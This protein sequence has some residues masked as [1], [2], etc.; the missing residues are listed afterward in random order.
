[1][2]NIGRDVTPAQASLSCHHDVFGM[3]C[4]EVAE[5]IGREPACV[6]QAHQPRPPASPGGAPALFRRPEDGLRIAAAFFTAS[7]TGDMAALRALLAEEVVATAD[8]GGKVPASPM[9]LIGR[10]A[11]LVRH[12]AMARDFGHDPSRLVRYATIDGLP[13]FVTVEAGAIVQ[14]TAL[15]VRDDAVAAIYVVRNPDESIRVSRLG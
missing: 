6:P 14:T 7:R 10:E 11:V 12:S 5:A 9:P 4:P 15:W 2:G 8:G 13:G 1:M 3:T